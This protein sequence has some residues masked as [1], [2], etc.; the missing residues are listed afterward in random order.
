MDDIGIAM[1]RSEEELHLQMIHDL[2]QI[3]TAHGL[4][5][6][7]SKSVFMQEQM[8]FLGVCINKDGIT[9]DPAK[10]AGLHKYPRE[11][12]NLKQVWGFLGYVGYH[13]M[14]CKNFLTLAK[15]L[16][17]LTKKDTPFVWGQEQCNM[18]EAIIQL[19][20]HAL[21]LTLLDPLQQFELETDTSQIGTGAIL[22]QQ[23]LV[24]TLPDGT[25]K[26][27][28]RQPCGF[29]SQKFSTTEQNYPIYDWEF[30][31]VM[32]GLQH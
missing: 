27:E 29:Y 8:D 5:L 23:D 19:I 12:Y 15:P 24:I 22:Y 11:L 3:L 14:F 26:P 25:E 18:Q 30:L 4:H 9:V 16:I 7:L 20:T 28:P 32:H 2:F 21:I 13:C 10:V 31:G 17:W 1:L 6:K